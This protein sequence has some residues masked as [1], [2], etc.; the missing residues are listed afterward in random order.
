MIQFTVS[1]FKPPGGV[2]NGIRS[3]VKDI[4]GH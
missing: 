4:K 2:C 3:W 1:H